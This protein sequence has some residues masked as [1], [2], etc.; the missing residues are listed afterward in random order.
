MENL[1]KITRRIFVFLIFF[2]V[3][4]NGIS[5]QNF[6]VYKINGAPYISV[7]DSV[8]SI[9]KGSVIGK[10]SLVVMH[11][12]DK[13]LFINDKGEIF[14]LGK[15]GKFLYRDLKKIPA[16]EDNTSFARKYLNYVWKEM[17]NNM[18]TRND[19]SGVVYRGDEIVLMRYP[20]D[21]IKIYYSEIKFKWDSI[22]DKTKEYYF[23]LKDV[24]TDKTIMIGTHDTSITLFVDDVILK[25]GSNYKWAIVETK[26]YNDSKTVFYNFKILDKTEFEVFEGEIKEISKFFAKLGL[27]KKEIR[28][29]ICQ[30]Y[31]ICY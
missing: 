12:N 26:Y 14:E 25:Q 27:T 2:F 1:F 5:Q 23:V 8:K 11:E 19:K 6:F 18:A 30:D 31:K 17:T 9:S 29:N 15:K 21:S 4:Q 24:D 3:V 16:I 28:K 20:A 13:L 10:N 22:K 7:K